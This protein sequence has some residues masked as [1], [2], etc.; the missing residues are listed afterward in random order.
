VKRAALLLLL[1]V[2]TIALS[3]P[4]AAAKADDAL[5]APVSVCGD[6]SATAPLVPRHRAL[7]GPKRPP[8]WY[9]AWQAWR[10]AGHGSRPASAPRK[11]P[12]WARARLKAYEDAHPKVPNTQLASMRC[13]HNWARER[14]G[15]KPLGYSKA[16]AAFSAQ[17]SA[18]IVSCGVFTHFPCGEDAFQGFPA[19]FSYEGE[20]LVMMAPVGTVR[21]MFAMWL[22]SPGHR[23][24]ILGYSFTQ[25]GL[26]LYVGPAFGSSAVMIWC[27]DFGG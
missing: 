9:A 25:F 24:N 11:I 2:A 18:K 6:P 14:D 12:A 21:Q 10:L 19:G 5:L 16:L 15:L 7:P 22:A 1:V 4:V 3:L 23:A 27:A 13:Y 17:K 26:H 20:N 8:V